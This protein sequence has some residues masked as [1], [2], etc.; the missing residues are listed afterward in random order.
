MNPSVY[1]SRK[2]NRDE[3]SL[4]EGQMPFFSVVGNHKKLR[5]NNENEEVDYFGFGKEQWLSN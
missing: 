1:P 5:G 2:R 3:I 4:N